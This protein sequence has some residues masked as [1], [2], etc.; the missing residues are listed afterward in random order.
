MVTGSRDDFPIKNITRAESKMATTKYNAFIPIFAP[1]VNINMD[2]SAI[3]GIE[4]QRR[5]A[6]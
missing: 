5:S 2:K 6:I 4:I 3:V 1:L